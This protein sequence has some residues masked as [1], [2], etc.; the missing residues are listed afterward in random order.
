MNERLMF[1]LALALAVLTVIIHAAYLVWLLWPE[2]RVWTW[3]VLGELAELLMVAFGVLVHMIVGHQ[4][5]ALHRWTA[6][7]MAL[8]FTFVLLCLPSMLTW[9]LGVTSVLFAVSAIVVLQDLRPPKHSVFSVN[10]IAGI[11]ILL[12]LLSGQPPLIWWS[13]VGAAMV[14]FYTMA[15]AKKFNREVKS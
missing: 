8:A 6:R 3:L 15:I 14:A 13:P 4:G 7:V 5:S 10:T 12:L 1:G 2:P 9:G 11:P